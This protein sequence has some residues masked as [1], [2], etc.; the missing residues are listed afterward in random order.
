MVPDPHQSEL[1]DPDTHESDKTDLYPHL[2][3]SESQEAHK[4]LFDACSGA[5]KAHNGA[6]GG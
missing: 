6:R 3:Q 2:R 4:N 5:L 1:M